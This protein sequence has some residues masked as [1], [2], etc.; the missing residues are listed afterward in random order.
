MTK[1][2]LQLENLKLKKELETFKDNFTKGIKEIIDNT[3]DESEEHVK[4]LCE[5][6]GVEVPC[7]KLV[8]HVNVPYG[9]DL[10]EL[11]L[12]DNEYEES[13]PFEIVKKE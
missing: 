3:C 2:E 8:I 9:R 1:T 11:E 7:T 6:V 5:I 12:W 4:S 10:D 13:I